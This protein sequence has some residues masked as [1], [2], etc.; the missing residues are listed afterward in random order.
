MIHS[1]DLEAF[2]LFRFL[3]LLFVII[4]IIEIY[5]LIE[6]GSRIGTINTILVIILT[7]ALGTIMLR[8]QGLSTIARVQNSMQSG[9]L[10][11]SGLIEGLM[12]LVSGALLLTPGFF[13]DAI[14]FLCLIPAVR[15]PVAEYILQKAI[16]SRMHSKRDH[17]GDTIID[18]EYWEDD[19][20]EKDKLPK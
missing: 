17:Q 13:T 16:Q 9:K 6:V 14:G 18:G 5:L 19:D 2:F 20:S 1:Q 11:A 7:A 12:L 8:Y 3:F 4:P 10:P 15:I